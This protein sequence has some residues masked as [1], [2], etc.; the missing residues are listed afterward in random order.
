MADE[1]LN[2]DSTE[3]YNIPKIERK[4]V[5]DK[6]DPTIN[7][8]CERIG[9]GT[10]IANTKFQRKY[11]WEDKPKVKSRLIESVLLNIPIPVIY[12]AEISGGKEEVIDG[13]QRV[14]T[15]S[16]FKN[17]EFYLTG[18]EIL[19]E[20]NRKFFRDLG[21]ELQKKFLNRGITVIKLLSDSQKDIKFEVFVRLNRGSL[22]LNEQELRNC[23]YSGNFNNLINELTNNKDF[24][25]LQGLKEPHRRMKDAERILRFFAFND[26]TERKYTSPAKKFL[27]EY[28]EKR[29][30]L[31]EKDL[32]SNEELF[33][34]SVELCKEVFGEFS[35][36][37][38]T[39]KEKTIVPEHNIN[40]GIMDIQLYGFVEYGKNQII[41]KATMI[42]DAFLELCIQDEE[43][44]KSIEKGTYGTKEVKLRTEKWFNRLRD[45]IGY[46][47]NGDRFYT[48]EDKKYLYD[49]AEGICQ[50]CHEKIQDIDDAQVD[51]IKRYS[52]GGKTTIENGEITHKY[53][54]L[55]KN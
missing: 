13:Q 29:R 9:N 53:C 55:K 1:N 46:P 19:S 2:E 15:F 21:E 17:N 36:R 35:F 51:H 11:V 42:K 14:L 32:K 38:P 30:D 26:L 16:K 40:D 4:I 3:N 28:I 43:F 50:L 12:T 47:E 54:N 49:K 34:K 33:K 20:L 52:E 48:Y 37:K 18:L 10:M 39:F 6:T 44:I 22:Q 31:P 27:N 25:D 41:P 7:D 23:I 5:T 8:I 24:L 45:I